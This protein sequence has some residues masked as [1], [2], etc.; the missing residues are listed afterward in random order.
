M[1]NITALDSGNPDGDDLSKASKLAARAAR[2]SSKL[3]GN[4]YK[5]VS[6]SSMIAIGEALTS[7][8][9]TCELG[10]ARPSSRKV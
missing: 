2:F 4:R 3:P 8:W 1:A 5:E 9:R 10:S 6:T 7:S